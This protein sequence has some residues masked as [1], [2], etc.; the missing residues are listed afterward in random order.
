ML[1]S[2]NHRVWRL[3]LVCALLGMVS[4]SGVAS[5]GSASGVQVAQLAQQ[6]VGSRYVWGGVSPAGFDC[7][8]FVLW[9][10]AEFGVS[11][12]RSEAGQLG[13]GGSISADNL[14]PGDVVVFANT[15][16]SGL[17]HVGIYVGDGRFA[18]AANEA[19]GVVV[20]NL[21]D[22]YWGP[23]FVGASRPLGGEL[24]EKVSVSR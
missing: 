16:R 7:T 24:A 21:W 20:S 6:Y 15:Y 2:V 18:H 13:S 17:S 12:P 5:A 10:Y 3:A 1:P 22:D 8:G 11:L 4:A 19:S 14:Q 9:V 23:R